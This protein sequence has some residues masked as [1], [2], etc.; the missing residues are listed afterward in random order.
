MPV[1]SADPCENPGVSFLGRARDMAEATPESRNRVVDLVRVTSILV[2]VFGHWLMAAVTFEDGR[3][4]PGHLLELADWTHPLTW[5]FQVMPLFFFVGGYSNALSWRSARRRGEPYGSWLRARLRRLALPVVPLLLVWM[6]GGWIGLR[7]GLDWEIL[8]LASQVALVPTWFLAAY[9]VIVTL[10]P[11]ALWLWERAGWWSIV[12]GLALAG[13][14][15]I[16]SIGAGIVW[17][18]FLNYVFVWGTVHQLGYA[19]VDDQ[20][21]TTARRVVLAL[22][23]LGTTLA[24]VRF[25]PYPVAMVGLDTAQIT[26]SYPPRVTL[27][28][29]G[30]FQAGSILIL[31]PMLSRWMRGL[32]PWT[33]VVAVSSRIM[34]LF[35]WHLT[36]MVIVIGLGLVTD[37]WGFGVE[38][39]TAT[40][41]LTRPIWFA[42]LIVPTLLLVLIFGRFERPESDERPAPA[43]WRPVVA[44]AL[45]CAGLG[46][47]AAIGIADEDG[48][49]GLVLSL[50][51]V[52]VV[53][54]GVSHL[55]WERWPTTV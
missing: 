10:A 51:I 23:G 53:A 18:G 45:V 22:V 27:A 43:W 4:V 19:W 16:L 2:V 44:V 5:V 49:N 28:F 39:L 50:P 14:A 26:N 13:L 8:Q 25:G 36:A 41:W 32:R 17:V 15:D 33:A 52:G 55:P 35:L 37:G 11:P 1:A 30:L 20:L 7:L 48:L 29:L 24:L 54:G 9:V 21:A 31:E 42:V 6:I 38:P 40:W 47:L 3:I 46:L 12:A 34:T